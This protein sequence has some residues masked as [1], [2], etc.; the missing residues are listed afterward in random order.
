MAEIKRIQL[1]GISR[2]PSDRMTEDGGVAESLNVFLDNKEV[3]PIV[4][5]RDVTAQWNYP[6]TL[7]VDY[8]FIH[9]TSAYE[10]LIVSADR[11]LGYLKD[12]GV[13]PFLD[14]LPSEKVIKISSLGNTLLVVTS[15]RST[16][17]LYKEGMYVELGNTVPFPQIRFTCEYKDPEEA[18]IEK[19]RIY[20]NGVAQGDKTW[21]NVIPDEKTWNNDAKD[22]KEHTIAGIKACL[23]DIEDALDGFAYE[24]SNEFFYERRF[25]RYCATLYD[26][27]EISS[28]P[29]LMGSGDRCSISLQ[30]QYI[31]YKDDQGNYT[32]DYDLRNK[33]WIKSNIAFRI[34]AE[35]TNLE[36]F[37]KWADVV[38]SIDFFVSVGTK[39]TYYV[40]SSRIYDRTECYYRAGS[41]D[42]VD[43]RVTDSTCELVFNT[44][45]KELDKKE[46]LEDSSLTYKTESI[47]LRE[48][49][50]NPNS[51]WSEKFLG[52]AEGIQIGKQSYNDLIQKEPL[53]QDDMQHYATSSF[54]QFVY[55][56]Q[57]LML[58]PKSV[59]SYGY[60]W[61]NDQQRVVAS[62]GSISNEGNDEKRN[63]TRT[64]DYEITYV[65]R[66][67]EGND[68]VTEA[69]TIASD[70]ESRWGIIRTY[71]FQVFPDPRCYRMIVKAKEVVRKEN[72]V[73]T[74]NRIAYGDLQMTPHPYLDCA[75]HFTSPNTRLLDLCNLT[76]APNVAPPQPYDS[77]QNAVYVSEIDNPFTFPDNQKFTFSGEVMGVAVATFALSQGQFG[78]YP[79]YVFTKD[80]VYAMGVQEDGSFLAPK[81]VTRD[82]CINPESIISLDQS[83]VFL[84]EKGVM[85][86]R[87]SDVTNISPYMLREPQKL[88]QLQENIIRATE[89]GGLLDVANENGFF[90]DYMRKAKAIYDYAG[91]R[92]F[93]MREDKSYQYIYSFDT[94]TWH[95]VKLDL[96]NARPLNSYPEMLVLVKGEEKTKLYD[97]SQIYNDASDNVINKGLII[98][99]PFDLG[100][101]DVLKTITDI[102][103]RG[104]FP[105]GA[106]KFIL[107][108]SNDGQ[109]FHVLNSLRTRSWKLFRLTLLSDFKKDDRISWV[110]IMFETRFTSKLR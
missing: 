20:E 3:A 18:Y 109:E 53:M 49:E 52:L 80:G 64:I 26:G 39:P 29:I 27:T 54:D 13:Q 104:Q 95:K 48:E 106:V 23:Q 110:D 74:M 5:P 67:N 91:R 16:Y 94:L 98:T 93:F 8:A 24:P 89:H 85:L 56:G 78:Q 86:L 88:S 1:R 61:L 43:N 66:D 42:V 51:K 103:V 12:G 57:M 46:L 84:S 90:M 14:L 76:E 83:V 108:G 15:E 17:I 44:A 65:L 105:K 21:F 19:Q 107:E 59:I 34:R 4:Q 47:P 102:R 62:G 35:L 28:M 71:S 10:K 97:F 6:E 36:E 7:Q 9:K 31:Q 101:P 63:F 45:G 55:N 22:G 32:G 40:N 33:A 25:I 72:G 92:L 73:V 68:L 60:N 87:G 69:I 81:P 38:K 70:I 77:A 30:C 2:A 50:N 82:V 79:L 99:R 37:K 96:Q 100:Y 75:Y 11:T 41:P 58:Q